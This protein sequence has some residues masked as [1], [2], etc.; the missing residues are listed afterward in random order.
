MS[1]GVYPREKMRVAIF[2]KIFLVFVVSLVALPV[3]AVAEERRSIDVSPGAL[4]S[5]PLY[6]PEGIVLAQDGSIYVG[7]HDGKI[8][9]VTAT[10]EVKDFADLNDLPGERKDRV[11]AVGIAM[12]KGG[13]I[14]AATLDSLG[15]AVLKVVGPGKA[16][17]GN[18]TLYRKGIGLANFILIDDETETMYV[19]DSSMFSGR[20]FRFDMN[21]KTLEGSAVDPETELLGKFSYANGLALGPEKQ[22]LYVAET[23]R[24]RV[25][26]INLET[27][28]SKVFVKT[29]GWADGLFFEPERRMLFVCDNK[30]GRIVAVDLSGE[31][32]GDVH[33]VGKE[34][35]CAPASLAFRGSDTIVFTDLWKASMWAALL[36]R[37]KHH[38]Y[39][40]EIPMDEVLR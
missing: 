11:G 29:G 37:P 19:S 17:S 31:I 30:G 10:G 21:D 33:L 6:G 15:G 28:E 20:V 13:D 9:R 12:D 38:S 8:R 25:S 1:A 39:V 18:V 22:F 32:K 40:Y 2:R 35:Q 23:T 34:G 4:N 7:E 36:G 24:G 14:Y 5:A 3:S 26:R 27:N 16:D